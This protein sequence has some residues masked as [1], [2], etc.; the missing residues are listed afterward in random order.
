MSFRTVFSYFFRFSRSLTVFS[1]CCRI[2]VG[3]SFPPHA[4]QAGSTL[5]LRLPRVSLKSLP[6]SRQVVLITM[7]A[8]FSRIR[9]FYR[10][11]L[12]P[13]QPLTNRGEPI[14][15]KRHLPFSL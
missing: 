9:R 5:P 6:H 1:V 10:P 12:S 8:V 3:S 11:F 15:L 13:P 7:F 2:G 14:R 4:G